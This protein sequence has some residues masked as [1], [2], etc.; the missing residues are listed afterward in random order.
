MHQSRDLIRDEGRLTVL[1]VQGQTWGLLT[2]NHP[3]PDS[4]RPQWI[5]RHVRLQPCG[6]APLLQRNQM[7]IRIA[8]SPELFRWREVLMCSIGTDISVMPVFGLLVA[9]PIW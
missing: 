5:P 6:H 9:A 2:A 4:T 8:E 7:Q 3:Q 1:A